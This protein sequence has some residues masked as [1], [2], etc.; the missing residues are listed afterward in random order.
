MKN[1]ETA[2]VCIN[3]FSSDLMYSVIEFTAKFDYDFFI[4]DNS[5]SKNELLNLKELAK[6]RKNIYLI[7]NTSNLGFGKAINNFLNEYGIYKS[8][9]LVNPD[10]LEI[11]LIAFPKCVDFF[12]ESDYNYFQP[13]I[14]DNKRKELSIQGLKNITNLN[15]VMHYTLFKYFFKRK[16]ISVSN[17]KKNILTDV[18]IPSAAFLTIKMDSLIKIGGFPSDTFLYFEEWLLA[19]KIKKAGYS[20]FGYIDSSIKVNHLVGGTTKLRFGIA[21]FK[22]LKIRFKA[23]NISASKIFKY[24]ILIKLII[25]FDHFLRLLVNSILKIYVKFKR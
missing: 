5:C 3:Y 2:F 17:L 1:K 25:L 19:N 16:T 20:N 15:V 18:Y 11:N 6:S 21:N 24:P 9:T 14:I 22:M 10:I 23:F 8:I 13:K 4:L 12:L 7:S